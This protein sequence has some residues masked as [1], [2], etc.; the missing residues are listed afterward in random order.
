MA[1]SATQLTRLRLLTGGVV[2]AS[3]ADYLTDTQLQAEYTEAAED[4]DTTVVYVLRLRVAM[5]AA[6]TDRSYNIEQT[7]ESL[8]QRHAHLKALLSA[9]EQR[10]G[11]SGGAFGVGMLDLDMD[12]EAGDD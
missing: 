3:E 1:L 4:W 5:T 7:S 12:A 8:S 2:S 6:L 10:A 9:A 11:L